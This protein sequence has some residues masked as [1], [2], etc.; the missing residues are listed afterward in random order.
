MGLPVRPDPMPRSD[1]DA[2]WDDWRWQARSAVTDLEG[3]ERALEL[4]PEEREGAKHALAEGFPV[5]ITPYYLSLA[6][7]HDPTCP[8][9]RQCVPLASEAIE[10]PG[11]LRDPLGEESH[12]VAPDLVQRYPDRV[13]LLAT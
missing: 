3:L 5:S 2:G 6:D 8:I 11:D 7:R 10:V 12:E 4:T 9:R 1:E 13:L